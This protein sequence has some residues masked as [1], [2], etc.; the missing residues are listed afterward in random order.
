MAEIP[1]LRADD[2]VRLKK[3]HPCGGDT[4]RLIR[5][6]AEVRLRCTTCGHDMVMD[7]IKLERAI[8]QRYAANEPNRKEG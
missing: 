6:G 2:L 4:F 8:K 7:R 1:I 3:K 5:I